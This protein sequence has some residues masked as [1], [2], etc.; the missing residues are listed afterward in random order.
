[1][2]GDKEY[3]GGERDGGGGG[4][5]AV[6]GAEQLGAEG[7]GDGG[8]EGEG[9]EG[10]RGGQAEGGEAGAGEVEERGHGEGVVADAAMGE[11][12]SDVWDEG[13]M[14]R[15][16]EAVGQRSGDGEADGG[17]GGVSEGD[18][19]AG[20]F[21]CVVGGFGA[22]ESCGEEHQEREVGGEGVVLLIGGEGEEEEDEGG[23]DCEEKYGA[24]LQVVGSALCADFA[25]M[26]FFVK[27][28]VC[29]QAH[30]QKN[31]SQHVWD[32]NI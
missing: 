30:Y 10:E 14:A 31:T 24:R 15:G 20:G 22:G 5:M 3:G 8:A 2:R 21:F 7:P 17:E 16:V 28:N 1:M 4:E 26:I 29:L 19:A 18:P 6:A 23:E 32:M 11:E 13:E 12:F 25:V 27:E 9:G